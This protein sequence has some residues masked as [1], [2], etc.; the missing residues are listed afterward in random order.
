[1]ETIAVQDSAALGAAMIAAHTLSGHRYEDLTR[2]FAPAIHTT[3]PDPA[4]R[5]AYDSA[6]TAYLAL[7]ATAT[8]GR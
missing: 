5:P 7:E 6:L 8:A 3:L 4:T 2:E 1:M